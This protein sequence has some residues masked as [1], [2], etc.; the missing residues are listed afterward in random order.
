MEPSHVLQAM[1]VD[2]HVAHGAI[3]FSL[4][5]FTTA[6]EIDRTVESLAE[7]IQNLSAKNR[8]P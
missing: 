2:P 5:R 8:E 6:A 4:S 7:I 3:R 1:G